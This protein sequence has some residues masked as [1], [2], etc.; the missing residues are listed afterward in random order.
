MAHV[1]DVPPPLEAMCPGLDVPQELAESIFGCLAK[2]PQ[3]RFASM[4]DVLA[5]LKRIGPGGGWLLR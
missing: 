2:D 4:D 3:D 5:S 1:N